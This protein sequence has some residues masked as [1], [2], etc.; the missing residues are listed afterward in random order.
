MPLAYDEKKLDCVELRPADSGFESVGSGGS[1][2]L[3]RL[4]SLEATMD[5]KLGIE[6]QAIQRMRPEDK[7]PQSWHEQAAMA[8][9]L[10][11]C[12]SEAFP[13]CQNVSDRDQDRDAEKAKEREGEKYVRKKFPCHG[14]LSPF[15][16]TSLDLK[17]LAHWK[18]SL[19]YLCVS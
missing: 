4:L 17:C 16:L 15:T 10:Y 3:D 9:L 8:L 11:R 6:L 18:H 5:S 12:A 13:Q 1:G 19:S 2:M 14:F 7:R